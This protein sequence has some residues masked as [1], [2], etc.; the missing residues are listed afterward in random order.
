MYGAEDVEDLAMILDHLDRSSMTLPTAPRPFADDPDRSDV[1]RPPRRSTGLQI[2]LPRLRQSSADSHISDC[3]RAS[4]LD[5]SGSLDQTT[6]KN[7]PAIR[8]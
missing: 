4:D 6:I 3:G 8:R 7:G 5:A 1:D 2:R